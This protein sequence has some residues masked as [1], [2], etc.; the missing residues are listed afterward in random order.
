MLH[1]Q[2]VGLPGFAALFV[3]MFA[4]AMAMIVARRRRGARDVDERRSAR[5]VIGIVV[6][7]AAFLLVGIAKQRAM[8]DPL[9]PLALGEALAIAL[10][11]VATVG[12]FVW[13]SW[14]MGRNWSVV[15]R[16]RSDHELVTSGPFAYVRHPIYAALA[17]F[18]IAL[19]IATGNGA[20]L[21][22]GL[23]IYALGTWLRIAE[24][25]RLLRAAFGGAYDAYATRVRRFVP[26]L[27]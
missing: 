2:P 21:I 19:A 14:T 15:A 20:R 17:L 4:F 25:E 27:F 1:S 6:Q 16:T 12:L 24:E 11:M 13:A 7:A 10:L 23:P 22:V 9:S 5:S 18:L 3:G 8:L 26:G